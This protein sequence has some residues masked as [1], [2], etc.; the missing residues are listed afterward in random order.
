MI[1]SVILK[2]TKKEEWQSIRQRISDRINETFG[3]PPVSMAPEKNDFKEIER[4]EKYGLTHIKI[5]YHVFD[6]QWN[7]AVL[8]LP[9]NLEK[10]KR[11]SAVVVTHGTNGF[12]GKYGMLDLDGNPNR[13]YAIELA[14]RGFVTISPDQYGFGSLMQSSEYKQKFKNFYNDYPEWS[15]MS[16]R[17]LDHIRAIDV[18]CQLDF[19]KQDGFGVMGNSL[20]GCAA[21]YLSAMDERIKAGVLSTGISPSATNIYRSVNG[22]DWITPAVI[23]EMKKDGVPPWDLHEILSLCAPRAILCLEP[24]NDPYNPFTETTINCVKSAWSVYEL[25]EEPHKLSLYLHG[26]GHNTVKDVRNF[27]YDWL[28][29]FLNDC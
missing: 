17:L 21:M 11:A 25:L 9:E 10:T 1:S 2:D 14:Q 15:L 22:Q 16:R 28:D 7:E 6:G 8:V 19:V 5:S 18:L 23:N 26:D 20:G 13:A 12:Q 29:R 27:A 24:F 3:K 4:Y